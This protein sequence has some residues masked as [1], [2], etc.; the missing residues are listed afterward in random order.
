VLIA[1]ATVSFISQAQSQIGVRGGVLISK[2]DFQ[3]GMLSEDP[4]SKF[5]A[6]LALVA[7]FG[8]G[9]VF[10][11]MPEFHWLQKGAKIADITGTIG[12]SSKIFD[13]FELPLLVKFK[14]GENA[15]FFLLA[16]PSIGYLFNA[17]DKDGD[18]STTDINLDDYKRAELGAHL[19]AGLKLGPINVDIRY[20]IGFSNIA[21]YQANEDLQIKNSGYGAGVTLL[22]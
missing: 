9:P 16:G 14:F 15:G 21:D 13:Y 6:D 11:I 2:Q 4:Q 22:F 1:C 18:G 3:N 19:G 7:E 8:I 10:A 17:T 20:I 5:G 12:E